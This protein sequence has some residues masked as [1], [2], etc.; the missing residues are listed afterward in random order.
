MH[1][2]WGVLQHAVPAVA[3]LH[4]I[5][6]HRLEPPP[7]YIAPDAFLGKARQVRFTNSHGGAV[8]VPQ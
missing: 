2:F 7:A 8:H 1:V 6:R 3:I 4:G 5:H